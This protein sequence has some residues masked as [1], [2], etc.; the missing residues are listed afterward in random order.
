[1]IFK[2]MVLDILFIDTWKEGIY[3]NVKVNLIKDRYWMI[4]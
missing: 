4:F 2:I 1:M 3:D